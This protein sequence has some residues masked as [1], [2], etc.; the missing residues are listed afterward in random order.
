MLK[1]VTYDKSA[2]SCSLADEFDYIVER[3]GKMK[4][5]SLYNQ[6]RFAKLRYAAASILAALPLFQLL[7]LETETN[8]L[9]IQSCRLYV[10]CDFF[11]TELHVLAY[12]KHKVKLLL[13]NCVE[14][15]D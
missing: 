9:F 8:N 6:H 4:H 3:E 12:F 1:L 7:L 11:L 15:S 2:N 14:I 10:E 13:L 5:M